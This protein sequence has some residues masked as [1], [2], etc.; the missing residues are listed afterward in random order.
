[1]D[2]AGAEL[3]DVLLNF[4]STFP[5][6]IADFF[7]SF[8]AFANATLSPLPQLTYPFHRASFLHTACKLSLFIDLSTPPSPAPNPSPTI[9]PD[10][11]SLSRW[12]QH[13]D[14]WNK[15]LL[16]D[17]HRSL[18]CTIC[19]CPTCKRDSTPRYEIQTVDH[20]VDWLLPFIWVQEYLSPYFQILLKLQLDLGRCKY[21]SKTQ[22][23]IHRLPFLRCQHFSVALSGAGSTPYS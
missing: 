23:R 22:D 5:G 10:C 13:Y 15:L 17:A 6:P 12:K 19:T 16:S 11:T 20:G 7:L 18:C 8:A 14:T 4:P 2:G 1:M 3:V 9:P 21:V